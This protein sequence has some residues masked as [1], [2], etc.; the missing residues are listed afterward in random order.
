MTIDMTNFRGKMKEGVDYST[1]LRDLLPT[2]I[3]KA[4]KSMFEIA[5]ASGRS[6]ETVR[7]V[8]GKLVG[9]IHVHE[10]RR[11]KT[12]WEALYLWGGGENAPKPPALTCAEKCRKYRS[13]EHGKRVADQATLRWKSSP[14]AAEYHKRRR[15]K[16]KD[17]KDR[18]KKAIQAMAAID[19][20]LAAVMRRSYN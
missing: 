19:P 4:P 6:H 12:G 15:K 18:K 1:A 11:Y 8:M 16:I 3:G 2:L 7:R 9:Q 14:A 13:T 17:A 5:E 20:L 10:W